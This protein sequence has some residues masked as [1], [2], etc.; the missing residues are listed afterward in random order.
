MLVFRKLL[1]HETA[2]LKDHL[3]R[4]DVEDR[5]L[6]FGHFVSPEVVIAYVDAISWDDTWIVGAFEGAVL[7]GVAEL[8]DSGAPGI[9]PAARVGELAVTVEPACRNQGIGTRLLEEALLIARNRGFETLYLLCL[10]ENQQMQRIARKF[11]ERLAVQ[12]SGVEVR[13]KS[14]QPSPLSFF[15]EIFGDAVAFWQTAASRAA[16]DDTPPAPHPP[17]PTPRPG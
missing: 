12:D 4:L 2:C 6:R 8:R 1:A 16:N 9:R 10:P 14:P 11:G 5:R 17:P 13:V 7:R 15:A 3:L